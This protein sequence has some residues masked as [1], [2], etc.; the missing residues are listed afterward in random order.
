[1]KLILITSYTAGQ[2]SFVN[3]PLEIIQVL[4]VVDYIHV[5]NMKYFIFT[6]KIN[7]I[8]FKKKKYI[9]PW[10]VGMQNLKVAQKN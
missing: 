1:M 3:C 4:F 8:E 5:I 10:I 9:F 7:A 2:G 6:Y